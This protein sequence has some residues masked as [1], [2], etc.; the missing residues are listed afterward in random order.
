MY[1]IYEAIA[2]VNPN[3]IYLVSRY[4]ERDYPITKILFLRS[5][6]IS[7]YL[8]LSESFNLTISENIYRPYTTFAGNRLYVPC[9]FTIQL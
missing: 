6:T 2:L 3:L 7:P 4:M 5:C 9:I 1:N 8:Q